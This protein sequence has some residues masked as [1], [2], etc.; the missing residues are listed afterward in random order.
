[1]ARDDDRRRG[2]GVASTWST[3]PRSRESGSQVRDAL[4]A[5]VV[6]HVAATC[7]TV[8]SSLLIA[9]LNDVLGR[10]KFE[11]QAADGRAD[12]YVAALSSD[13]LEI[14]DPIEAPRVSP[15]S[16]DDYLFALAAAA[17]ADVIVSGDRHLTGLDTSTPRV[18][19]PRRFLDER[20]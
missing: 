13:A 20:G 6:D 4:S 17:R 9:E 5:L 12:A 7:A 3:P 1:M 16:D 10:S 15:D 14:D 8:V 18:L 11:R 19:P 2:P